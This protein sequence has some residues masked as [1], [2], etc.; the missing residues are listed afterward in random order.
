MTGCLLGWSYA[1]VNF[2]EGSD[3]IV[4]HCR[5]QWIGGA[6][7]CEASA[8]TIADNEIGGFGGQ[9]CVG[10]SCHQ[11]GDA[12]IARNTFR[13]IEYQTIIVGPAAPIIE[14][15]L[16]INGSTAVYISS[17]AHIPIVRENVMYDH[18][19]WVLQIYSSSPII[20]HNT[21]DDVSGIGIVLGLAATPV[22]RGNI[23][24]RADAGVL[25]VQG[26]VPTLECNDFYAVTVPYAEECPDQTGING[27]ISVDPEFCGNWDT[28]DYRLQ[29]DSPCAPGNHPDG[30]DCG[31]IG[32]KGV[33]CSTTPTKKSSWGAVK[34][35]YRKEDGK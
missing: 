8:P 29:S 31:Q 34:A 21:I 15:N 18:G 19:G 23:V 28:V 35:L 13:D 5:T 32:A 1:G 33:G 20:E 11:D 25:C 24:A 17:G 2:Y 14:E 7:V 22:V 12:Y 26:S 27:N 16:F 30:Y 3:A 9:M 4:E 10:V 6:F